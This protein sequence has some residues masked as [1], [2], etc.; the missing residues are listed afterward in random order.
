M[1]IYNFQK[2][3]LGIDEKDLH[4]LGYKDLAELRTEVTAISEVA[5]KTIQ[6]ITQKK[7]ENVVIQD[8]Y[9]IPLSVEED[10]DKMLD[11]GDL[12]IQTQ[13]PEKPVKKEKEPILKTEPQLHVTPQKEYVAPKK[14]LEEQPKNTYVFDPHI[15]SKELGLPLDLIEEFIQ[16]FID[17]AND[18]KNGLYKS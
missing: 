15:A 3:F 18:F 9:D 12:S 17:Q 10:L 8:E 1:L 5:P 11:V 13:A 4:T 16:D 14:A 6:T 2:E 7:E